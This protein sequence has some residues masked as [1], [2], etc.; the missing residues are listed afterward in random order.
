MKLRIT[1]LSL[2][3]C[4]L[5]SLLA[6][7]GGS[8]SSGA[9]SGAASTASQS[10]EAA[11][12]AGD[13]ITPQ[14]TLTVA[15]KATPQGIDTSFHNSIESMQAFRNTMDT[16]L[17]FPQVQ[18]EDGEWMQD[19]SKLEG[20]LAEKWER[21]E[22]GKTV[23]FY[24]RKGV[25]NQYGNELCAEDVRWTIE[26]GLA[27]D[28]V[29]SFFC[30]VVAQIYDVEQVT[31][32]DDY[33]VSITTEEPNPMLE[34]WACHA[35]NGIFDSTE[36][37]KHVTESDPWAT[38]WLANNACAYGPFIIETW[39]AGQ[40]VVFVENP[41]YWGG[42]QPIRKVIY[43]EVPDAA[44]RL[45]LI[46]SGAVDMVEQLP[47]RQLIEAKDVPGV[48][49]HSYD[50]NVICHIEMNVEDEILGNVLVRQAMNYAF[51]YNEVLESVLFGMASQ[52]KSMNPSTYPDYFGDETWNYTTDLDKAKELL[53][54]AGYGNG[55]TFDCYVDAGVDE[56]IQMLVMFQT[57]LAKLGVTMNIVQ[58]PT[59]D[60]YTQ[61]LENK[62]PMSIWQDMPGLPDGVF[63]YA[64]WA[65]GSSSINHSN[66]D[67]PELNNLYMQ[68]V[69][70]LDP[71][72]RSEANLGIQKILMEQAPWIYIAETGWHYTA[73]ENVD[74]IT[75]HTLQDIRWN[76]V[77]KS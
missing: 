67:D 14:E 31:V 57:N 38:E 48:K 33:T 5:L 1:A 46:Q 58:L 36:A 54:E 64:L 62:F 30:T 35:F 32:I 53:T 29:M 52:A 39:N 45:A 63:G 26:R 75:W 2:V 74:G 22:D 21:S 70:T 23:T 34:T 43:K 51:P 18:N 72:E 17:A 55:F 27:L 20:R 77:S 9:A 66:I 76:F 73:R 60:F 4:M 15:A 3:L 37:K 65:V 6:G 68:N 61:I 50:S 13:E 69:S 12:P 47:T 56:H 59:G 25:K 24:L 40:E 7:C 16:L 28:A 71:A 49:V 10:G 44:N 19:F 11:A 42:K 8:A 41:N